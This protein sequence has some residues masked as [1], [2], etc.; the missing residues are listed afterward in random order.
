M[1]GCR[2]E[3]GYFVL[4]FE[5]GDIINWNFKN[6]KD[7][8]SEKSGKLVIVLI[9]NIDTDGMFFKLRLASANSALFRKS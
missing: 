5:Q 7:S 1:H 4:A 3:L 8:K 9:I 2:S 6:R